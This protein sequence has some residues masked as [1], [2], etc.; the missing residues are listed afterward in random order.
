MAVM[1]EERLM[2]KA[3]PIMSM[4]PVLPPFFTSRTEKMSS[5]NGMKATKSTEGETKSP[6]KVT[7][8]KRKHTK[9]QGPRRAMGLV[10]KDTVHRRTKLVW[11]RG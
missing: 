3:E 6:M 11:A 8:A 5:R 10:M 1:P 9:N 4:L 2:Q 7:A